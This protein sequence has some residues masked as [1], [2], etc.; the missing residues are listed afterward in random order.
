MLDGIGR[1][2]PKAALY[3]VKWYLEKHKK[4]GKWFFL[5]RARDYLNLS[6]TPS[7]RYLHNSS[8]PCP[9]IQTALF[10]P[11]IICEFLLRILR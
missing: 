11:A 7:P 9:P 1:F 2:I 4:H 6:S 10:R 3:R 5:N 8:P